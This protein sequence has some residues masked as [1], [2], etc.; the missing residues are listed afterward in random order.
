MGWCTRVH[1]S[2]CFSVFGTALL[3]VQL[4]VVPRVQFVCME[5]VHSGHCSGGRLATIPYS[6]GTLPVQVRRELVW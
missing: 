1:K 2:D 4:C 3:H 6:I 5:G